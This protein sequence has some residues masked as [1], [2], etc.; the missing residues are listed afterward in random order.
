MNQSK[1]KIYRSR[2]DKIL[3]GV[4]AGLAQ[5]FGLDSSFVRLVFVCLTLLNGSGLFIYLIL[6]AIMPLEP[7]THPEPSR[8]RKLQQRKVFIGYLM[9]LAGTAFLMDSFLPQIWLMFYQQLL[10]PLAI[11]AV[12]VLLIIKKTN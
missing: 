7:S 2:Q 3:A 11:I 12:G 6:I 1:S 10:W 5:R 8:Q 9:I 4:C